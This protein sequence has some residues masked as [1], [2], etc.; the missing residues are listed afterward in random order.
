MTL[1]LYL[2]KGKFATNIPDVNLYIAEN[3]SQAFNLAELD[4]LKQLKGYV[5]T[6]AGED[7]EFDENF[8]RGRY[9]N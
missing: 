2:I 7:T 3:F 4:G 8:V 1:Q 6:R 9:L 5:R